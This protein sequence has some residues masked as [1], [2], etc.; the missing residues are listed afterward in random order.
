MFDVGVFILWA[1]KIKFVQVMVY[2]FH[3]TNLT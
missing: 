2:I 3:Q 1:M